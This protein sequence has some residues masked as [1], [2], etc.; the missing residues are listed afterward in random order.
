M[1]FE[2]LLSMAATGLG[3]LFVAIPGFK[4]YKTVFPSK[5]NPVKDAQE[6]LEQAKAEAEAAKLNKKTEELYKTLYEEILKDETRNK[7]DNG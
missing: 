1:A 7:K 6:K 4:L 2:I 5:P 3:I